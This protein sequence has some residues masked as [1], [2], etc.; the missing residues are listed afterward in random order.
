MPAGQIA[1]TRMPNGAHSMATALVSWCTRAL[2][3]AVDRAA[4]ADEPGDRAGVEDHAAVALLLELDDG[5]LAAEE[6]AARSSPRRAGRSPRRCAPRRSCP[7]RGVGMPT[8]LKRMSSRPKCPTAAA[9]I[10]ATSASFDTSHCDGDRGAARRLDLADGL[11]G[12]VERRC[13]RTRP[14][15]L[16]GEAQR[17]GPADARARP[18]DDRRLAF[19]QHHRSRSSSSVT[20]SQRAGRAGL[21]RGADRVEVDRRSGRARPPSPR[22]R[23]RTCPARTRCTSR[24]RC[25]ARGRPMTVQRLAVRH[26][27]APAA[28]PA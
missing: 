23:G 12:A 14:G 13:R 25:T 5:V 9:I 15:A 10:A 26:G 7:S 16:L 11:L 18:R 8:L 28:R 19:E 3:G 27:R 17:R 21:H 2:G 1:F 6:H 22:R 24:C 20:Q 4:P